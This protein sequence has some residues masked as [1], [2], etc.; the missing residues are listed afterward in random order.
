LEETERQQVAA[1]A[2]EPK[3]K[4]R[5]TAGCAT[6]HHDKEEDTGHRQVAPRAAELKKIAV[7]AAPYIL[8]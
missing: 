3:T 2:A 8:I 5:Y 7:P 4:R 1:R 6:C